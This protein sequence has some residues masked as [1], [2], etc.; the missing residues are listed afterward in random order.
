MKK[1]K[2]TVVTIKKYIRCIYV[3]DY[4]IVGDKPYVSEGGE[5]KDFDFTLG[6]LQ[7]AF[8]Q[9]EIKQKKE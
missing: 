3:N 5:Y 4:R 8:P 7:D 1:Y 6:N 2:L 9:L